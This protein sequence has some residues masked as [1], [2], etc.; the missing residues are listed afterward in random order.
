MI[1]KDIPLKD[2]DHIRELS[3]GVQTIKEKRIPDPG[4]VTTKELLKD[5]EVWYRTIGK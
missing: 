2:D 5:E 4:K 3:P 1:L